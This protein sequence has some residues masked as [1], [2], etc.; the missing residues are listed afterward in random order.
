MG[1]RGRDRERE[2]AKERA[3]ERTIATGIETERDIVVVVVVFLFGGVL[4][5]R[6][7][8]QKTIQRDTRSIAHG[9]EKIVLVFIFLLLSLFSR[10]RFPFKSKNQRK[11]HENEG[12][13]LS[14]SVWEQRK[15]PK[16]YGE[17]RDMLKH[18]GGHGQ[19]ANP[20]HFPQ[21]L[22][23]DKISPFPLPCRNKENKKEE[24]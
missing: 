20:A 3:K 12:N 10:V 7:K 23:K 13:S 17:R 9:R 18:G 16:G 19:A 15:E 24:L 5:S 6:L 14:F 2:K 1:D 8:M 21:P 22:K 4:F 11:N